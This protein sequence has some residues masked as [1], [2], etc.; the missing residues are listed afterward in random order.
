MAYRLYLTITAH[1]LIVAT[2]CT[3]ME[4][5][6]NV[7]GEFIFI[8]NPRQVVYLTNDTAVLNHEEGCDIVNLATK[9]RIREIGE[10]HFQHLAVHPNKKK[11]ALSLQDTVTIYDMETGI[12]EWTKTLAAPIMSSTFS[13]TDDTLIIKYNHNS[14]NDTRHDYKSNTTIPLPKNDYEA[15]FPIFTFHPTQRLLCA[16]CTY[17]DVFIYDQNNLEIKDHFTTKTF[18]RFC[19]YNPN[20]ALIAA[21]SRDKIIILDPLSGNQRQLPIQQNYIYHLQFH[22]NSSILAT[23]SHQDTTLRYWDVNTA[24]LVDAIPLAS[25]QKITNLLDFTFYSN[26]S[27]SPD[28]Q[29]II[30]AL[31]DKCLI[32]PVP[33]GVIYQPGTKEKATLVCWLL[34][35]YKP[36]SC[37]IPQDLVQLLIYNLLETFKR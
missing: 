24:Q 35:N 34:K 16:A 7:S 5:N 26:L 37:A 13:P 33:F 20:G 27:F 21:G 14:F 17:V 25:S 19:E 31:Q 10:T 1:L 30:I 23:L 12:S 36:D 6:Q 8:K 3:A 2:S 18:N 32:L 28:G 4:N 22:P 9:T 15:T 29:K 11:L